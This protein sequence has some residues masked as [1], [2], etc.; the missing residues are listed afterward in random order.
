MTETMRVLDDIETTKL[1]MNEKKEQLAKL[2][3]RTAAYEAELKAETERLQEKHGYDELMADTDFKTRELETLDEKITRLSLCAVAMS[4]AE[5]FR[6]NPDKYKTALTAIAPEVTIQVNS[7]V[8]S[9]NYVDCFSK[10]AVDISRPVWYEE[11]PPE[12]HKSGHVAIAQNEPYDWSPA[13]SLTLN[14]AL[15]ENRF[16]YV[17]EF[18]AQVT[19]LIDEYTAEWAEIY[20]RRTSTDET[21]QKALFAALSRKYGT[22]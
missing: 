9:D 5:L 22:A 17:P 1:Y 7:N 19:R 21:K 6:A 18:V 15:T 20:M 13:M 10:F 14:P 2:N 8:N 4:V 3:T 11:H 16:A 12:V